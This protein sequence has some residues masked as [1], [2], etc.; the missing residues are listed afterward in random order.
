ME[1]REIMKI[2]EKVEIVGYIGFYIIVI[3]FLVF[4]EEKVDYFVSYGSDKSKLIVNIISV[5][6]AIVIAFR[7]KAIFVRKK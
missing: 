5:L 4:Y 2:S 6:V 1:A 7:L 3:L